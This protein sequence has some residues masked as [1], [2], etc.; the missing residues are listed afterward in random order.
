MERDHEPDND[1]VP[2][3]V[4]QVTSRLEAGDILSCPERCAEL[5]WLISI[6]AP[7]DELPI[8]YN[9]ICRRVRLLFGDTL[10]EETGP[11]ETDVQTLI[12]IAHDLRS[13]KGKMLIH[14][15]AG[16]S[17]STAAAFILYAYWLGP[18]REDEA[19]DL[20]LTQRPYAIP[21]RRMVELADTLL[22]RDGRLVEA[23]PY[24]PS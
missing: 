17:R 12:E 15:E 22:K 14:C 16:I 4:I 19:M 11:Q 2:D 8:D 18:G 21:N 7:G 1:N 3:L 24:Q 20:V 23:L 9:N 5:L 6:G 13:S 10:D